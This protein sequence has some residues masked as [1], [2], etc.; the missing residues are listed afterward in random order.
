MNLK[1]RNFFKFFFINLATWHWHLR[2]S[3]LQTKKFWQGL[4][5]SITSCILQT[6]LYQQ[7]ELTSS[8]LLSGSARSVRTA[9]PFTKLPSKSENASFPP[10]LQLCWSRCQSGP[11]AFVPCAFYTVAA[12][13]PKFPSPLKYHQRRSFPLPRSCLWCI[14]FLH[15]LLFFNVLVQV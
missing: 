3:A 4:V 14:N 11:I 15:L 7:R 6:P 8:F 10:H 2:V 13:V 1:L 12:L 5:I 9:S